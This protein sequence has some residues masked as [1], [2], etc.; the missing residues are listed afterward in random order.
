MS[1][2]CKQIFKFELK[3]NQ[4]L[5]KYQLFVKNLPKISYIYKI[6]NLLSGIF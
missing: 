1:N 4:L 2:M 5:A 6:R 3:S